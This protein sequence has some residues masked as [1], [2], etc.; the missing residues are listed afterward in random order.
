MRI[1][2]V[3]AGAVPR[4]TDA[5]AHLSEKG[6]DDSE[7]RARMAKLGERM[8]ALQ[9]AL[10]AEAKRAVLVVLQARDGAGKD[11]TIRRVFGRLNPQGCAV[12]GFKVPTPLE[13]SHDFLWRVHQAVPPRGTIGVFNRSHYEDVLVVRVHRLVPDEVW[14]PRY[15][16]INAFE[17]L[18]A[19]N[20]VTILKFFLH[21]S[22]D[23]QRQRLRERLDDPAKYWKFNPADLGEREKWDEYTQAYQ[24]MLARTS[25]PEA[26]WYVVP[27]D[28]K[29]P[30]DVLIA[31]VVVKALERLDPRFPG[32]PVGLEEFRKQLA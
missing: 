24:D 15:E 10:Y 32:P 6:V 8:D 13:R 31:E 23:E 1:E 7:L 22:K 20:D 30:R 18:L 25:T 3:A 19:R 16:Q 28:K 29:L 26:P 14:R 4:L 2:P 5:D 11:S 9:T 21:I 12:T 27:A 17:H